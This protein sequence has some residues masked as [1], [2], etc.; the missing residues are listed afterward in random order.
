MS[1]LER[2]IGVYPGRMVAKCMCCGNPAV[3]SVFTITPT[4]WKFHCHHCHGI[5]QME[6]TLHRE[7]SDEPQQAQ[8]IG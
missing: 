2:L 3:C 8:K 1:N 4:I 5:F 6:V 7:E